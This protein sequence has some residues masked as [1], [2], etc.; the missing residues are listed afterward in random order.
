MAPRDWNVACVAEHDLFDASSDAYSDMSSDASS[1]ASDDVP[2]PVTEAHSFQFN[3]IK[4]RLACILELDHDTSQTEAWEDDDGMTRYVVD[5]R[6]NISGMRK[7]IF[8]SGDIT[9]RR[10]YHSPDGRIVDMFWDGTDGVCEICQHS[11]GLKHPI[12][13]KESNRMYPEID[14]GGDRVLAALPG[15]EWCSNHQI[16]KCSVEA[17][18]PL[19]VLKHDNPLPVTMSEAARRQLVHDDLMRD[20]RNTAIA[21]L[22]DTLATHGIDMPGSIKAMQQREQV[23]RDVFTRCV[24]G[25]NTTR[26]RLWTHTQRWGPP[27]CEITSLHVPEDRV[28]RRL[29]IKEDAVLTSEVRLVQTPCACLCACGH[30]NTNYHTHGNM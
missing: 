19:V 29:G 23:M 9:Y 8:S 26:A 30:R 16:L 22:T 27:L 6:S 2:P 3:R 17:L 10:R 12:W 24:C 1:D 20:I 21:T 11:S 15:Y 28:R 14:Y 18:R 4:E 5:V 13:Y 25:G 7:I